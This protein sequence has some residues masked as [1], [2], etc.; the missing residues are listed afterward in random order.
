MKF[1][2]DKGHNAPPDTG[3]VSKFGRE[4]D[5][6]RA[7]GAQVIDKL[8][9]LGHTAIDCTPSSASGVLDSLYQ[10]VQA[11]N[12]ARVDVYVSIHF[13]AFNGNAKGTEIFAISAAA[14]RIA[15]PVLTS[16]VSLG[17]T[18][19]RVKDGSHLYVL[20]NTAMPA[21]LVECCFLDSA[22]DMQRY[23]TATMVNAIVKGLAGKLPDPPPTVKP[24]DDNVLKLQKSLNR[25]QIRDANNQVL[26]EDG[27]SG[28]AT[29]S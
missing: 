12:S 22:E 2:I 7:V 1:G 13:N 24:T 14:R 19:R 15:E 16:I 6:T 26:K 28:P 21:I 18:N 8:R 17:F 3:A 10:R 25:L 4:D 20:R 29:E 11:A 23:D 5:L 9:A 27:I